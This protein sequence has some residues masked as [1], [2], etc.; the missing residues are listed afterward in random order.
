MKKKYTIILVLAIIALSNATYLSSRA[1]QLLHPTST[2][3]TA[4]VCDITGNVS[5]TDVII[6][7]AT[8]IAGIPFSY[9]AM[10]VYPI[11]ILLT[12]WGLVS[13]SKKPA[14]IIN[15]VALGGIL[16]N[17]YIISQEFL[18]VH[19][20]C[21]LCL[22]CTAIIISIFGISWSIKKS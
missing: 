14:T 5:C 18:Y 7:P 12:I 16:F 6:H 17:A 1:Y 9:L 10:I 19:A 8:M 2:E 4:S 13:G 22:V 20:Y 11:L 21:L 3:I 15:W